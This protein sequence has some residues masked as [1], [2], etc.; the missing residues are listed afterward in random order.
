MIGMDLDTK[1]PGSFHF[2]YGEG[3]CYVANTHRPDYWMEEHQGARHA[4]EVFKDL[5]DHLSQ[6]MSVV[7]RKKK[8]KKE[9]IEAT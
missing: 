4:N 6:V 8:M 2:L 9:I 7:K 3:C 1:R 5:P